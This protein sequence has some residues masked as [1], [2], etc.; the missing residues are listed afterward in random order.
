MVAQ[1]GSWLSW[2]V[3]VVAARRSLTCWSRPICPARV[4]GHGPEDVANGGPPHD[5]SA[6]AA[7][8]LSQLPQGMLRNLRA[9]LRVVNEREV[10][11][12]APLTTQTAWA[13]EHRGRGK[14]G[15]SVSLT[16]IAVL[17]GT[18]SSWP[19]PAWTRPG[20]GAR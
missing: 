5:R 1:T 8:A 7:S 12:P 14:Y 13:V 19:V 3:S 6:D 11:P 16:L 18:S 17:A 9:D 15:E 20:P 2:A 4:D 10:S